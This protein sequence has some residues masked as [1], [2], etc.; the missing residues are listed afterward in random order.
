MAAAVPTKQWMVMP[1]ATALTAKG[2]TYTPT[3]LA[4]LALAQVAAA[5]AALASGTQHW[6]FELTYYANEDMTP[7]DA[8]T[9]TAIVP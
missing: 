6:I 5:K 9:H 2:G 8:L 3:F 7:A 1:N 4:T